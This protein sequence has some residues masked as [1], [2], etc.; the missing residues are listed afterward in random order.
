MVSLQG[1]TERPLAP[2]CYLVAR[3]RPGVFARFRSLLFF[4]AVIVSSIATPDSRG[5]ACCCVVLFRLG[6]AAVTSGVK[7]ENKVPCGSFIRKC[8]VPSHITGYEKRSYRVG[9]KL[10]EST[11]KKGF[12]EI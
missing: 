5:S 7:A 2:E 6:P 12:K 9:R 8:V 1:V 4:L 11:T 3:R 10:T